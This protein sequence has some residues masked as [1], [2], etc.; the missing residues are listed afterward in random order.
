ML[1]WVRDQPVPC[2]FCGAQDGDGHLFGDCTFPTLVEIRENPKF[3]SS[4]LAT[5]WSLP[6]GF[7]ADKVA[8][9]KPDAPEVWT[10][11]SLVLDSVTGVSA[12]GAG[13]FA[14]QYCWSSRRWGHVDRVR[15][16]GE[17][18]SCRGLSLFLGHCRLFSELS[19]GV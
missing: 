5:E 15:P 14:H 12:A 7:D 18:Q 10:G 16:E 4:G 19:C 13:F 3:H 1:G 9:R 2:R 17:F 8:A 11:G 6:D